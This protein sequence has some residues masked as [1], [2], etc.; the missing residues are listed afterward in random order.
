MSHEVANYP[1]LLLPTSH[2]D[3]M[4]EWR[5]YC[6]IE[7]VR[8]QTPKQLMDFW[9][10]RGG[11]LAEAATHLI[12]LPVTSAEVERSFSLLTT[13][14]TK[15]HLG[16]GS[17]FLIVRFISMVP[18]PRPPHCP[19]PPGLYCIFPSAP[20]APTP[21]VVGIWAGCVIWEDVLSWEGVYLLWEPLA[22][23]P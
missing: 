2:P 17:K 15:Y 13:M 11:V 1:L 4:P 18:L 8:I 5:K 3:F 21:M 20:S 23:H 16:T 9:G 22:A 19:P 7:D 12:N 6:R 10:K 14:D